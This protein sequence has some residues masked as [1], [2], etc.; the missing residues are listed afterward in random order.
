M[1]SEYLNDSVCSFHQHLFAHKHISHPFRLL[2]EACA[3]AD[4]LTHAEVHGLENH[5]QHFGWGV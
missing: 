3:R 2:A 1:I 5:S 4:Q